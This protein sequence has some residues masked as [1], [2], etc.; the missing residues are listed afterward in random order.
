MSPAER[1][2][3]ILNRIRVTEILECIL[4]HM[5]IL[6]AMERDAIIQ[7]DNQVASMSAQL[8]GGVHGFVAS[9]GPGGYVDHPLKTQHVIREFRMDNSFSGLNAM[10]GALKVES[11]DYIKGSVETHTMYGHRVCCFAGCDDIDDL[12]NMWSVLNFATLFLSV[13][14]PDASTKEAL[15]QYAHDPFNMRENIEK[16]EA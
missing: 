5:N 4:H 6:Q 7:M 2:A 9:R 3:A 12:V 11:V 14:A 8:S 13:F 1:A 15:T 16:Q 10:I